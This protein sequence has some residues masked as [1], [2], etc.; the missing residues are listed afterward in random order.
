MRLVVKKTDF[1]NALQHVAKAVPSR[2]PKPILYGI[3]LMATEDALVVTAYDLELGIEYTL[4][5]PEQESDVLEV[6]ASGGIVLQ[7]RYLIDIVRKLPSELVRIDVHELIATISSGSATYTING[8]DAREFPPLPQV[9]DERGLAMTASTLRELIDQTVYAIATVDSRP[10]LTGVHCEHN[11]MNFT[12]TATD[13]YRLA[14]ATAA[15]ETSSDHAMVNSVVP[16]K[17]LRE[18]ARLLPEDQSIV[19]LSVKDNQLVIRAGAFRVYSRLLEGAYPD[20]S[21]II[22]SAHKTIIT[23]DS[24]DLL[25]CIERAALLARDVENHIVNIHIRPTHIEIT[26]KSP[27][28]GRVMDSVEPDTHQGEDLQLACNARYLMDGLRAIAGAPVR[29]QFTGNGSP[30]VIRPRDGD[31][32]LH[33][34]LPVRVI[35]S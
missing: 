31:R 5:N 18:I 4:A 26:S 3:L 9:Y 12:M 10:I 14:T 6:Q 34:I 16:G 27:E 30:F 1:L 22:P 24:Q 21:R 17:A 15:I 7:A 2:T 28:I 20:L 23:I 13:S 25:E 32:F 19:D 33:L 8:F 11:D 29:I 35:G